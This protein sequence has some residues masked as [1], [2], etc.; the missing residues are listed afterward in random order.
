M[1]PKPCSAFLRLSCILSLLVFELSTARG[2]LVN[3]TVDDQN[4][5]EITKALPAYSPAAAWSQGASCSG[6]LAQPDP[7]LALDNTW[8]DATFAPGDPQYTIEVN[9]TGAAVYAFFI[10]ANTVEFATTLTNLSFALDGSSVGTFVHA[11]TTSTQ[12]EYNVPGYSNASLKNGDH[13]FVISAV[14]ATN[15]SLVLFD[16]L[17]YSLDHIN[18]Q[19]FAHATCLTDNSFIVKLAN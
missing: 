4:G 18:F 2:A 9:F 10:I 15:D 6:C 7:S 3:V 1:I 12:Y 14:G 13:T 11:P 17:V 5:D 8:H 16:Y 19:H